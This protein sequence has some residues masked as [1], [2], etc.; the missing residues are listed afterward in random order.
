VEVGGREEKIGSGTK[1][2]ETLTLIGAWECIYKPS[3]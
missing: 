2:N 3:N 1:L